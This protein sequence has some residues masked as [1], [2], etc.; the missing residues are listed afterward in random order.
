MKKFKKLLSVLLA[1]VMAFSCFS[2]AGSAFQAYE[3]AG[4]YY[5][6]S[7][8]NPRAYLYTAEQ[9]ASIIVDMIDDLLLSLGIKTEVMGIDVD[10]R[11]YD[12]LCKTLD[13]W[14]IGSAI[15]TI[16]GDL[17]TIDFSNIK[18]TTRAGLGD[19][20]VLNRLILT[21]TNS[22]ETIYNIL[23]NGSIDLGLIG[24]FANI[25][26]SAVE[27]IIGDLPSMLGGLIYGIGGRKLTNGIGS[28]P[29]WPNSTPWDDLTVDERNASYTIDKMVENLLKK[30]LAEPNNTMPTSDPTRNA[31]ITDPE[32]FGATAAM[33]HQEADTGLYYI[34][35][36]MDSAGEWEF[37]EASTVTNEDGTEGDKHY[38]CQWDDN[39]SLLKPAA[40]E[41]LLSFVKLN[42]GDLYTMLEKAIPWAYNTF[43]GHNLDGQLRAT[44]MQFC[45]AFNNG[46]SDKL[47]DEVKAQLT[48][49]VNGYKLQEDEAGADKSVLRNE[50]AAKQGVAGNYNFMYIDLEGKKIGDKTSDS[51]YYVVEWGG[52]WEF[53]HVE[54]GENGANVNALF[55]LI[56]WEYQAP[57]WE[58]I[59]TAAGLEAGKSFLLHI[60]DIVGTILKTAMP[61]LSWTAGTANNTLRDNLVALMKVVI[62]NA[63]AEIW[64]EHYQLPADFDSYTLEQ[65]LVMIASELLDMLMPQL[66]LPATVTSVE[67][68]AVYAVREF[69]AEI[70]P[71]LGA[72]W[73]AKIDAAVAL[74]GSAKEDAFLDILLNM[75]T[76]IGAYYLQNLIGYGT[77]LVSSENSTVDTV[78]MGA[79]YSWKEILDGIID[80]VIATWLPNLKTNVYSKF[81]TA[82]TP[83][84]NEPLL[85]LSAVFSALFPSVARILGADVDG[86]ALNLEHVYSDLRLA[87]NGDF[88]ALANGLLRQSGG[89]SAAEMTLVE[90]IATLLVELF[91]GLGFE[92][93]SSWNSLKGLFD[94]AL[95]ADEPIQALIGAYGTRTSIAS[96]ARYFVECL[97]QSR[98]IWLTDATTF[99]AMLM[100]YESPLKNTGVKVDGVL[101]AYTGAESFTI[102][103]YF[104]LTTSGVRTYFNN[105]RYKT[106]AGAING[107]TSGKDGDYSLTF[108]DAE[109]VNAAGEQK[110][111]VSY[112]NAE[113]GANERVK[114]TISFSGVTEEIETWALKTN[115]YVNYPDGSQSELI[116]DIRQFTVSAK[117]NDSLTPYTA[118]TGYMKAEDN[119]WVSTKTTDKEVGGCGASKEN[120]YQTNLDG[121]WKLNWT[122]IY[123]NET[124]VLKKAENPV[125][126]IQDLSKEYVDQKEANAVPPT[127]PLHTT[128]TFWVDGYGYYKET[129]GVWSIYSDEGCTTL[130]TN[131][132][133][134]SP[135][136]LNGT[137]LSSAQI[138]DLWFKWS[139]NKTNPSVTVPAQW[140]VQHST[141]SPAQSIWLVDT[142]AVRAD[143]KDDFYTYGSSFTLNLNANAADMSGVAMTCSKASAVTIT[144]YVVLYNS[145]G[146]EDILESALAVEEKFYD[147]TATE[148]ATF[149]AA[150]KEAQDQLY[151]YWKADTFANDH[152]TAEAYTYTNDDDEQVTI[153]AG[154]S[155]FEVV[156]IKLEEA[157]EVLDTIKVDNAEDSGEGEEEFDERSVSPDDPRHPLNGIYNELMEMDAKGYKSHNHV[158]YRWFKFSDLREGIRYVIN[159]ATRP[160]DAKNTLAGYPYDDDVIAGI[161]SEIDDAD[162]KAIVE[163]LKEAPTEEAIKAAEDAINAWLELP[164]NYELS[165]LESQVGDMKTTERRLVPKYDAQQKYFLNDA[166][167]KYGNEAAANYS[168]ESYAKYA[169][170][171]AK[172][173]EMNNS[174]TSTQF[175]IFDSRYHF[176]VAYNN[177]VLA[178]EAV[179]MTALEAS[180]A[181]AQAILDAI[182]T[183]DEYTLAADATVESLEEAYKQLVV[184][185]GIK[186]TYDEEQY[187]VGG[188]FSGVYAHEQKGMITAAEQQP[189]VDSITE[190]LDAAIANFKA[191]VTAVP[192]LLLSAY[193][194]EI[195]AVISRDWC[196]SYD[197]DAD[198]NAFAGC[199][200]G[201]DTLGVY[202]MDAIIDCLETP[203]GSITVNTDATGG[204]ETTGAVI[205]LRD[206]NDEIVE[207]YVF[208][209][210]GDVDCDGAIMGGDGTAIMDYEATY[211]GFEYEY[212]Q[213]AADVDGDGAIM[214]GDGV[215]LI[216]YEGSYD[217]EASYYPSQA[218]L[219]ALYA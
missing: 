190:N 171:R 79:E 152:K 209:Y 3:D 135:T 118:D 65:A 109:V 129:D 167:T 20:E 123:I 90:A 191:P 38:I 33:I 26:L 192:E 127:N 55:D 143:Y 12:A 49:I 31:I 47:T 35:G 42:S 59:A 174:S 66:V 116:T 197:V 99:I 77:R 87:L 163:S 182:K 200:M 34:Y 102:N 76:S 194:E 206:E 86:Y 218:E 16:A 138:Q 85:K 166:L 137:S 93:Q 13:H 186:V 205:E 150:I 184:A 67:E 121:Q 44:L 117:L 19:A 144:P 45:G 162:V 41:E 210:F 155:T 53:Y 51:L 124:E 114:G 62:K 189:W 158:L 100:G 40:A 134:V 172:A 21:L 207:R 130:A 176:L 217:P 181:E 92:K 70:L 165:T 4:A 219:A 216:D 132:N 148:W 140:D 63:K 202:T 147:T 58:T 180:M 95:K 89:S 69:T 113:V 164:L 159:A 120:G 96:L 37:T 72:G 74:S 170:A 82:M 43:G 213:L 111:Y 112:G 110:G 145:Y 68:V 101:P 153:D 103:Y 1:V 201:I 11:S 149:Q 73:D 187:F 91:G 142:N 106:S 61:T 52:A 133:T 6:D 126:T 10:L 141:T 8:D 125:L 36:K 57:M 98:G 7:N 160:E 18:G 161:I 151:G 204:V 136:T 64:G 178:N 139:G 198:G 27:K 177:L 83:G 39:S 56:D 25:D 104:E 84:N 29:K 208:I 108:V 122:N 48:D 212:L 195:G 17:S 80:W 179:D 71:H 105:G 60:N 75:G 215:I 50:F 188:N 15:G 107:L 24:S 119:G 154:A 185:L 168:A 157:M 146:L 199:V 88:S 30:L 203:A 214:G 183:E 173:I 211:E 28:D 54:L 115:Y 9:R 46:N 5:Y 175:E 131:L 78:K 169:E 14:L 156:G 22:G 193:G 23:N 81:T 196:S 2:I 94:N 128:T 97:G 32:S